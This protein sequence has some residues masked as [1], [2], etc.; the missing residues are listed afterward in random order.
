MNEQNAKVLY[1]I[2]IEEIEK[3]GNLLLYAE[4]T[5]MIQS[6]LSL[7]L[8]KAYKMLLNKTDVVS[9]EHIDFF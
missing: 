1:N 4:P 9:K 6:S 3:K 8:F 2:A 7:V 5:E